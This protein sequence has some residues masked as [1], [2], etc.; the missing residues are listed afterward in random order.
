MIAAGVLVAFLVDYALKDTAGGWRIMLGLTT[1]LACLQFIC[2]VFMPES[3]VWLYDKGETEN[4]RSVLS[5]VYRSSRVEDE[6]TKIDRSLQETRA[7][8]GN[9]LWLWKPQLLISCALA[10]FQ[11]LTANANVINY[12]PDI[13]ESTGAEASSYRAT[14]GVGV[15]KLLFTA[16]SVAKVDELGRRP[17]LLWGACAITISLVVL[18][19][20][21]VADNAVMSFVACCCIVASYAVSYGPV[22]WLVTAELSPSHIRGRILGASQVVNWVATLLVSSFFLRLLSSLGGAATFSVFAALSF[23]GAFFV[24][25]WVPETLGKDVQQLNYEISSGFS[26]LPAAEVEVEIPSDAVEA[27]NE[28][29]PADASEGRDRPSTSNGSQANFV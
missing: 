14:I 1:V 16:F 26:W 10:V 8:D 24:W 6:I 21:F 12:A 13:F 18:A 23:C 27:G 3:P 2:L 20:S 9:E 11:E 19:S 17:L 5:Q 28:G 29:T 7:T 22:T 4:A 15:I 25:G